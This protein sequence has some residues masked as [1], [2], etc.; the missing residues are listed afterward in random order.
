MDMSDLVPHLHEHADAIALVRSCRVDSVIHAPA[1]YQMN[2]GRVF[3]GYP[4][5]G[6][7]VAYGLGTENANLPAF[8]VMTQ[9]EGTPEGGA[10]AGGPGSCRRPTRGRSSGR[11]RARS[12]TS[13]R[14]P[15]SSPGPSSGGRSTCSGR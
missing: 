12:S 11:A 2:C 9:P 4:S 13:S 3:M 8:V 7:W 5:L 6:S 1:H 10:P 14:R 15:A